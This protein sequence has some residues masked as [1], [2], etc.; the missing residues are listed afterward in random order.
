MSDDATLRALFE[1]HHGVLDERKRE[2][3]RLRLEGKTL[4]AVGL[5]VPGRRPRGR[6]LSNERVR[7]LFM[8][9]IRELER[10]EENRR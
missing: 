1:R 5:S 9:A 3:V 8:Q 7:Q 2:I 10:A 6:P 4:A